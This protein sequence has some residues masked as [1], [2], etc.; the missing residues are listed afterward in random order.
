MW[1]YGTFALF[2]AGVITSQASRGAL[3][4]AS[5]AAALLAGSSYR[6]REGLRTKRTIT[7][8]KAPTP[9][10]PPLGG[11]G[12]EPSTNTQGAGRQENRRNQPGARVLSDRG[13]QKRHRADEQNGCRE[14]VPKQYRKEPDRRHELRAA[15]W[16]HE[17]RGVR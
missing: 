6:L 8:A 1:S 5:I 15:A 14:R 10:P 16:E 7:Y 9:M 13:N 2:V 17:V 4:R 3:Y 11:G 12:G